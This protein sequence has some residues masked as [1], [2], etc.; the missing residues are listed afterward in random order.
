MHRNVRSLTRR[1]LSL[2]LVALVSQSGALIYAADIPTPANLKVAFIGD[3]GGGNNFISVLNLIK[4]EGAQAVF[5]QGDFDYGDNPRAF[6]ARVDSVLGA[7]F[8][9]FASVGNHDETRWPTTCGSGDGNGCYATFLKDRMTRIGV[10]PDDPNLNDEMYSVIWN[11]LK[12][13][14]VGQ[15]KSNNATYANYITSQFNGDEHI[16]KVSSWHQNQN[17]M[18]IGDK[19]DDMGWDVYE[20]SRRAGALIVTGHEH[21]YE[22]TVTL[23]SVMNQTPDQAQ[24]PPVNGVPSAPNTLRVQQ[25]AVPVI[26]SGLAGKGIRNQDR[27]TPTTYPYGGGPGCNYIWAKIYTSDQNAQYGVLFITFYVDGD[28]RKAQAYFKTVSGQIIDQFELKA[29]PP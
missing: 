2:L 28:P 25:G 9:Y 17:R 23:S 11:G 16:W 10:T 15:T 5:H 19:P 14:F 20:N 4:N 29:G 3:S 27:C 24:H 22:R 13:V 12:V 1:L 26:V 21:S 8:P 7:N 18:Q 6:F